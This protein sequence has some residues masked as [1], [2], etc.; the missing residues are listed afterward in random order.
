S[1]SVSYQ[2]FKLRLPTPQIRVALV[3]HLIA[4]LVD[5]VH[6]IDHHTF[7]GAAV[8]RTAHPPADHL[9]VEQHTTRRSSDHDHLYLRRIEPRGEDTVVA[10]ELYLSRAERLNPPSAQSAGCFAGDYGGS[11]PR[12]TQQQCERL[13]MSHRAPEDKDRLMSGDTQQLLE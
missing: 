8:F 5:E 3:G 6:D 2:F 4:K 10:E 1:T 11:A 7:G 13:S 12:S 9:L